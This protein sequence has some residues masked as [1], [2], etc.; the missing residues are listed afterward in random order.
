M[1]DMAFQLLAF[2]VLT[3]QAPSAET[4]LDLNLPATPLALPGAS[5]GRADQPTPRRVD[6]DIEND[7]FV[8]A[9]ADDLGDL[10]AL[11]LGE[12]VVPDLSTLTERLGRYAEILEGRPLRVRLVADDGLRY[13][14][15]AR[16]LA[17]CAVGRRGR[18]SP[19]RAGERAMIAIVVLWTLGL[20]RADASESALG[21]SDL[22]AYR[23]ALSEHGLGPGESS[24][25]PVRVDFRALW[26][27]PG[28]FQGRLVEVRGRLVRRF[29]QGAFGTFPPLEEAWIVAPSGD[30]FCLVF[31]A[32]GRGSEDNRDIDTRPVH[33]HVSAIDPLR[34]G[35][36]TP[37]RP[38]D[39]RAGP[40]GVGN[41]GSA[42]AFLLERACV[43]L[44]P[45]PTRLGPWPG[46]GPVGRTGSGP[47]APEASSASHVGLGRDRPGPFVR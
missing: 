15:A 32:T 40:A 28:D 19:C 13:E 29:R 3:F 4:H 41:R 30:P 17:A 36:R 39:R 20:S 5:R 1:L 35:R 10:K 45:V 27:H 34:G 43:R 11:R 33:R 22:A 46:R 21:L 2:F 6:T 8:R 14:E 38:L 25:V 47:T 16:I 24:P 9:Q 31:P 42:F 7:L 26:D 12:A 37:A 44:R 18:R 23:A